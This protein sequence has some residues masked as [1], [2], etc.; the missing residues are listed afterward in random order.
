MSIPTTIR[1]I[2][3][4][5]AKGIDIGAPRGGIPELTSSDVAAAFRGVRDGPYYLAVYKY[6]RDDSVQPQLFYE[7]Y[8]RAVRLSVKL[9]WRHTDEER[10]QAPI[11]RLCRLA[12]F[13]VANPLC[14]GGCGGSGLYNDQRTCVTCNGTGKATITDDM[15]RQFC[16]I[17]EQRWDT[18]KPRYER[19]YGCVQGWDI[20]AL[21][22]VARNLNDDA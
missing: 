3:K 21:R 14:C 8:D 6:V 12:I 16:G 18:W 2:S 22:T 7:V 13:E 10:G 17:S 15:R 5:S 19:I 11:R 4:L 20:H 1:I 9:N